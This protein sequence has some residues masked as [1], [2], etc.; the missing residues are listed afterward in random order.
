MEDLNISGIQNWTRD[1]HG[2]DKCRKMTNKHVTY[3]LAD[4]EIKE[5]IHRYRVNA[6]KR[7]A[8]EAAKARGGGRRKTTSDHIRVRIVENVSSH[9]ELPA[10]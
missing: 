3:R 7:R 10:T 2:R 1:H 4:R 5:T 9:K 8:E 6:E